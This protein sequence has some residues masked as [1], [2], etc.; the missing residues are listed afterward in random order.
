M[1]LL[2]IQSYLI[3][4]LTLSSSD[5]T[6]DGDDGPEEYGKFSVRLVG[7]GMFQSQEGEGLEA[8]LQ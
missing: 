5:V 3:R 1:F 6:V 4:R 2:I 7:V 8:W